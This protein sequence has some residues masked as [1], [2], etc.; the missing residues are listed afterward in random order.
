ME[1]PRSDPASW[2]DR[3]HQAWRRSGL[4]EVL[5]IYLAVRIGLTLW[6]FLV[7]QIFSQPLP[8][9]PVAR[10]YLGVEVETN[11]WLEPWQRWD[12]LYFQAI[13]ERGYEPFDTALFTPPLYP[14]L[15]RLVSNVSN[16]GTLVGGLLI[17]N[18]AYV[19]ALTVFYRL[20]QDELR[21]Q[22]WARRA[23]FYLAIFPSAFF[24]LAAYTEPLF[25][26]GATGALHAARHGRWWLSG[27]ASAFAAQARLIGALLLAP[28]GYLAHACF[29]S[30][31]ARRPLIAL[32]GTIAGAAAFP[33]Y[34][35]L[36][37][38][39]SLVAPFE[40]QSARFRVGLTFPGVNLLKAIERVLAGDAYFADVFDLVF[41][42]I[43][44]ALAIPVWRRLSKDLAI[45]YSSIYFMYLVR[46]AVPQPLLGSTRYV[47]ILFPAFLVLAGWGR[48]AW[49]HR[50]IVYL[51]AIGL[52]LLSGQFAIWGWVG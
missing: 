39:L 30:T 2:A 32:G 48:R 24:F 41:M 42:G 27:I 6:M 22:A 23:L 17:S 4:R 1:D 12:T 11:P 18:L 34:V 33:V 8:P 40:V 20:A 38:G 47:L 5:P 9:D 25:F 52:L 31:K 16:V 3:L 45:Y 51:S 37:L 21:D 7:R 26:L 15:I 43:F 46:V 49:I 14:A 35:W 19:A 50:L 10:P 13:A 28:L 29:R 44:L 36:G